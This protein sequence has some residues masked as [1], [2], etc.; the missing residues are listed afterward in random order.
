MG[1][2]KTNESEEHTEE[3]DCGTLF[4]PPQE[5]GTGGTSRYIKCFGH[6][7]LIHSLLPPLD[8]QLI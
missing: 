4:S 2:E 8:G 3:A 5:A 6:A 7:T 1:T